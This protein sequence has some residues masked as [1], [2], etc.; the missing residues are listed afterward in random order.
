[1]DNKDDIRISLPPGTI[2]QGNKGK[3]TVINIISLTQRS[4]T[5][6]CSDEEGKTW[7]LKLYNGN[8][9]LNS[10]TQ[11]ALLEINMPKG[12]LIPHDMGE[13]S[14]LLFVVMPEISAKSTDKNLVSVEL[15]V[16]K[17]IPQLAYIV[18]EYHKRKILLRDISPSHILF[19]L[20]TEEI[21]YCGFSN[22]ALLQG[23]ATLTKEEGFGQEPSFLAPEV[24]SH[25]YSIYS[26]YFSLGMTLLCI[27]KGYNPFEKMTRE[28][29]LENLSKGNLP[30]LNIE[31]LKNTSY[32]LYSME[33]RVMY[34]ILGLMLPNPMYRWGY[35]E[36]RCWINEYQIPLIPKGKRPVY[37]FSKPCVLMNTQCWNQKQIAYLLAS[38]SSLWNDGVL[39][40][41]LEFSKEQGLSIQRFLSEIFE[42]EKISQ[43]GKAFRFIYQLDAA[44]N[45]FWWDGISYTNTQDILSAIKSGSLSLQSLSQMLQDGAISYFEE[46]R[47]NLGISDEF[48]LS[49]IKNVEYDERNESGKGVYKC[50][51]LFAN[52]PEDRFFI[53]DGRQFYDISQLLEFYEADGNTLK[54][55]SYQILCDYSFQAWLWA[56]GRGEYGNEAM[57]FA[58]KEP[59]QSFMIFLT[60]SEELTNEEISKQIARKLYLKYGDYAPIKWLCDHIGDYEVTKHADRVSYDVLANV[61]FNLELTL[62]QL[63]TK[64]NHLVKDYQSFVSNTLNNPFILENEKMEDFAF[65]Y[66][67]LYAGGYFCCHWENEIEVSP[68]FLRSI[69]ILPDENVIREWIEAASNEESERMT[70]RMA[71]LPSVYPSENVEGYLQECEKN[72][73][74]SI[75]SGIVILVLFFMGMKYSLEFSLLALVVAWGFPT[76]SYFWY[77]SKLNCAKDRIESNRLIE[78]K[79]SEIC[80][81]ISKI[82]QRSEFLLNGLMENEQVQMIRSD[83]TITTDLATPP[84]L[85]SL[86]FNIAIQILAGI[87]LTAVAYLG[88]I[89]SEQFFFHFWAS[90]IFVVLYVLVLPFLVV[91]KLYKESFRWSITSGAI[92]FGIIFGTML[93]GDQ[94]IVTAN[95]IVVALVGFGIAMLAGGL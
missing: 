74:G 63:S 6:S 18:N 80:Q 75:L 46:N 59:S 73:H 81:A 50:L 10:Q 49:E 93:F 42:D 36:I 88:L 61:E 32:E 57:Y 19:Q 37:Q 52:R 17:I 62:A 16:K 70:E 24:E 84:S 23:N 14:G 48:D 7:R 31:H 38:D 87:S 66:Y 40:Q 91:K 12:I 29:F 27:L 30:D 26:D 79:Q 71:S 89:A 13:I 11:K 45:H 44:I 9:S 65:H 47:A 33:D 25:G 43:K 72:M 69:G 41:I 21:M 90:H 34:L 68:D 92:G 86:Q 58:Q 4:L 35:G 85:P 83:S 55:L 95:W 2:L 94:F 77:K 28:E 22:P 20:A 78:N 3:Y 15:L 60:V 64:A 67:P 54:T 76:F 39:K 8:S 5:V 53:V 51:M 56:K 1:M 82:S